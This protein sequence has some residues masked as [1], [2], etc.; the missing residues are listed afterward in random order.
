[1]R[2]FS[3]SLRENAG[4]AY[5]ITLV[6]RRQVWRGECSSL[7]LKVDRL[8]WPLWKKSPDIRQTIRGNCL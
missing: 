1:M 8:A 6:W 3:T 7:A 4:Y 2:N 5:K